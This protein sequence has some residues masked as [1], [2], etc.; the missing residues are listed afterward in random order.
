M[1][2]RTLG[3]GDQILRINR[4]LGRKMG[5]EGN[6][7]RWDPLP[8]WR[9]LGSNLDPRVG[10]RTLGIQGVSDKKIQVSTDVVGAVGREVLNLLTR[11]LNRLSWCQCSERS[12]SGLGFGARG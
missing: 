5:S 3:K 10:E 12:L 4:D 2:R 8:L 9:K 11:G 6:P 7:D 1:R